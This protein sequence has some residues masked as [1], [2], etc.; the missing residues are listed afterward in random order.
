LKLLKMRKPGPKLYQVASYQFERSLLFYNP[1]EWQ[2]QRHYLLVDLDDRGTFRQPNESQMLFDHMQKHDMAAN[3][4]PIFLEVVRRFPNTRTARD[5][6]FTAAV[7]H[8][9]LR[10]YN[11]YWRE[12][13]SD[14]GHAGDRLVSY[15]D[16]RAA[17]PS[18]RFPR[19]TL[20]WEP[21]A[22]TV[23]GGRWDEVPKTV[24]PSR[25]AR[26]AQLANR[27]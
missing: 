11:N 9:R 12:I 20:G 27:W 15:R 21:A 23:N 14:G 5:A 2:G 3:S 19:G 6:M 13:Y 26:A 7:C 8:E 24:R 10:E 1:L 25:W 18:Y 22:R 4:L 16:V 17:Y